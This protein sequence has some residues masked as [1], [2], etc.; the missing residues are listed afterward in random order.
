MDNT[1]FDFLE[2]FRQRLP[3]SVAATEDIDSHDTAFDSMEEY[4][5]GVSGSQPDDFGEDATNL[6]V[7]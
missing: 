1:D 6:R 5:R 7:Q 4:I 3:K 2:A